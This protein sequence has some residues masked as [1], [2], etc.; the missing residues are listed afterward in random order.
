MG[1]YT[2]TFADN[3]RNQLKK[4]YPD[5]TTFQKS[6]VISDKMWNDFLSAADKAGVKQDTAGIRTSG[7]FIKLQIKALI[8]RDLW[9]SDAYF[10]VINVENEA[11]TTAIKAIEDN[12]FEKMKIAER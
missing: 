10:E 11:L 4:E 9:N 2:L 7:N 5:I 6:Y 8:A 3:N 12:T 1:D